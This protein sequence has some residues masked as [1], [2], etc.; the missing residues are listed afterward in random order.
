MSPTGKT[1]ISQK[2]TQPDFIYFG[3][4]VVSDSIG[5]IAEWI[6]KEYVR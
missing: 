4:D 5:S 3:F 1:R 2:I 6:V